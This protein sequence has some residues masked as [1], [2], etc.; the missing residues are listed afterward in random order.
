MDAA[1]ASAFPISGLNLFAFRTHT[2][3][4]SRSR[5]SATCSNRSGN[6][7]E[8]FV[9][10]NKM[11]KNNFSGLNENQRSGGDFAGQSACSFDQSAGLGPIGVVADIQRGI[12]EG[13]RGNEIAGL[14]E[15]GSCNSP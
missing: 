15:D 4:C 10:Q 13:E 2:I 9:Y 3:S 7:Q 12:K 6:W 14:V 11:I 8:F 1:S 5:T